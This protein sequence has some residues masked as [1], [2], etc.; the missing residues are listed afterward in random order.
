M[1]PLI[2]SALL[3]LNPSTD[4]IP[5]CNCELSRIKYRINEQSHTI[6]YDFDANE[7]FC[8]V[9]FGDL[10]FRNYLNFNLED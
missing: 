3:T 2:F 8:L 6:W 7:P 4:S 1:N 10:Y 5:N 9:R